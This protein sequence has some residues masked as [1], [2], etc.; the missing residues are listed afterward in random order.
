[1]L[2]LVG[3]AFVVFSCGFV[4]FAIAQN[5]KQTIYE[6]EQLLLALDYMQVQMQYQKTPLPELCQKTA[7]HTRGKVSKA[8]SSF[9]K[10]L[11]RHVSA[12]PSVCMAN[13]TDMFWERLPELHGLF[14]RLGSVLGKFDLEGQQK[15]IAAVHGEAKGK[16]DSLFANK[17]GRMRGYQTLGLCAGA[18]VAIL[19][20]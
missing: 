16:L 8:F 20:L 12:D 9:A 5:Y 15:G 7:E 3:A 2:K 6:L 19:L 14:M 1:M 13:A 17:E 10:E 11:D 4:G 18:A